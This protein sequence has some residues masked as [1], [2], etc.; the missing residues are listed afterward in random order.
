M[1]R[2][3]LLFTLLISSVVV[4]IQAEVKSETAPQG[5]QQSV[6]QEQLQAADT[7]LNQVYQQLRGSLNDT[8]KQQLKLAQRDWL[9]KRDA[10]VAA[11]PGN[12]Q[13]ALYQATMLRVGEL[14]KLIRPEN[15]TKGVIT[16]IGNT[17]EQAVQN[18]ASQ[19]TPQ[20]ELEAGDTHLNQ[21][22]Q[23]LIGVL[24]PEQIQQ[25]KNDQ[26][27]WIHKRDAYSSENSGNRKGAHLQAT[28]ERTKELNRALWI[29]TNPL[30]VEKLGKERMEVKNEVDILIKENKHNQRLISLIERHKEISDK[31]LGEYSDDSFADLCNLVTVYED[32]GNYTQA[33]LCQEEVL[34]I[35]RKKFGDFNEYTANNSINLGNLYSVLGDTKKALLY[36]QN[37][38]EIIAKIF[39]SETS[40]AATVLNLIASC[41]K[42]AGDFKK[43]IEIDEKALSIIQSKSKDNKKDNY[44]PGYIFTPSDP[45][46]NKKNLHV[47]MHNLSIDYYRNGE[48]A[49]AL[50][51]E[52]EALG[53]AENLY[54]QKP[55][56]FE[57]DLGTLSLI[58]HKMGN[59]EESIKL[60]NKELEILKNNNDPED[61]PNIINNKNDLALLYYE[62]GNTNNSL[63][64][65]RESI[66]GKK[67]RM[68]QVLSLDERTRLSWEKDNL[69]FWIASVLPSNEIASVVFNWKG[70]VLDSIAQ[71]RATLLRSL[72][73]PECKSLVDE[74]NHLKSKISKTVFESGKEQETD[75]LQNELSQLQRK[76]NLKLYG[77]DLN[78]TSSNLTT[79]KIKTALEGNKILIDWV[80]FKDPKLKGDDAE[81][82]GAILTL[83]DGSSSFV[84]IDGGVLLDKA[85]D[86]LREAISSGNE[87]L[88]EEQNKI[89][90]DKLWNPVA[91]QIPSDTK[92]LYICPDGKLNFLSFA[93]LVDKSGQ[94]LCEKYPVS[95]LG[96]ARDLA[97]VP[98]SSSLKSMVIFANPT[99][100]SSENI[101]T[102]GSN[103][104][105]QITG[106]ELFGTVK[107]PS[108]PGTLDEA[109]ILSSIASDSGWGSKLY[110]ASDATKINVRN[111]TNAEIIHLATHGFYLNSIESD[112][113]QGSR[114]MTIVGSIDSETKQKPTKGVDPMHASGVALTGAQTTLNLWSQ[115]KAPDPATDGIL[116]AEEV[117]ALNLNGAW[118][119]TLSACE[120]GVG[121]AQSGEGVFGLRRAFMMAGAQN[122]LMTLWPV[123]DEVTPKIMAD[124]YKVALATHNAAGSLAK[125]QR[126]WLVKLRKE[127]GLLAAVRDAG[128]FAMVVMANPNQKSATDLPSVATPTTENR[129]SPD[130]HGAPFPGSTPIQ[131]LTES[132]A[133]EPQN[134]PIQSILDTTPHP[135][136]TPIQPIITKPTAYPAASGATVS[137]S[138]SVAQPNLGPQF[139]NSLGQ[140]FVPIPG[141]P[142]YFCIWD[143]RVSDYGRFV[144]ET[145]RAWKPAGF[146]QKPDHPAVRINYND[147]T[148][149][150]EWLTQ[151]EHASGKLPQDCEYRLPKDLEWSA[152]AGIGPEAPGLPRDRDGAIPNCYAWGTNWPPPAGAGNFDP[153]LKTD[154]FP[155]TSPVGSFA[156]NKYGLY[157][158]SG[159]VFQWIKED[160]DETGLGFLRGGS[161][162]DEEE[163][164]LNLSGRCKESKEN[165]YKCYGF[166]CVIAPIAQ[167]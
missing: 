153:K 106:S 96:S 81:C 121:E 45:E 23:Q 41:Y 64:Y 105:N 1:K 47:C 136:S 40:K 144:Q 89:L 134:T 36:Y 123:S 67:T 142:A 109:K 135:L 99:F 107:L 73:N 76:L 101:N 32:F 27:Q 165:G 11:N 87:K 110:Q 30:E 75:S 151:K 158:I 10:F 12:P 164:N 157:D 6:T 29:V 9:K 166:R 149:F 86:S 60:A 145:G 115:G 5:N 127:K 79:D 33:L 132:S 88:F 16:S 133:P 119:V 74:I 38:Y 19:D 20:G 95:Y 163:E 56:M 24:K 17:A 103:P 97:R 77:K 131:P 98:S 90:S 48:L 57:A 34:N 22:Y 112:A 126:D 3:I 125:V 14:E 21:V 52:K 82:Y 72:N 50:N 114:G 120:T 37:A 117:G 71:D 161:W 154:K 147:A 85:I 78:R 148:A 159:N 49:K 113:N 58:Y 130:V 167:K 28:L 4:P 139:V 13:G 118:L 69:N 39:G 84:R 70:V 104:T 94:F 2:L 150:C 59:L 31:V 7:Q 124:F 54:A 25:L 141:T 42:D 15:T 66:L 51:L 116:T 128:P 44:H 146:P 100:E 35:S 160:F 102:Q 55:A 53:I 93:A 152:A 61:H 108:L 162:P 137:E 156:P 111:A 91:A 65:I 68:D 80:Q 62:N 155:Y 138:S 92:T 43:A 122:L 129:S 143:T 18:G 63:K 83:P 46:E 140:K 8:Q 26:L